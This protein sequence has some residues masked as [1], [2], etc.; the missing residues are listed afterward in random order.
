MDNGDKM[1][2]SFR[3]M[4]ECGEAI[5]DRFRSEALLSKEELERAVVT[6]RLRYLDARDQQVLQSAFRAS[7]RVISTGG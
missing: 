5:R 6:E 7:V 2:R 3:G 4:V 1:L